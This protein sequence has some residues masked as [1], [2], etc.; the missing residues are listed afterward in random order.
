[1]SC[2]FQSSHHQIILSSVTNNIVSGLSGIYG[3][4]PKTL[5][6]DINNSA[7]EAEGKAPTAVRGCGFLYPPLAARR[8]DHHN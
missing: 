6:I 5:E 2:I 3:L 4:E 1:M 7:A 8:Q